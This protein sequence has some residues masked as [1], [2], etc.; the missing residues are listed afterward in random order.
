MKALNKDAQNLRTIYSENDVDRIE[1]EILRSGEGN[2]SGSGSGGNSG[3]E[4]ISKS[5]T[6]NVNCSYGSDCVWSGTCTC[7]ATLQKMQG[8]TNPDG[9]PLFSYNVQSASYI[10]SL[11]GKTKKIIVHY[12]ENGEEKTKEE[13]FTPPTL[14]K[15]SPL[16]MGSINSAYYKVDENITYVDPRTNQ[17]ITL[18]VTYRSNAVLSDQSTD[19]VYFTPSVTVSNVS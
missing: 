3:T 15:E 9:S 2:G 1:N 12:I 4:T 17:T 6:I 5:E 11:T 7:S 19:N 13:S 8:G 10:F 14:S 18:K 16:V